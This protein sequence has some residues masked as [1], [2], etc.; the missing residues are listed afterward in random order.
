MVGS[1]LSRALDFART[2]VRQFQPSMFTSPIS[3]RSTA[4]SPAGLKHV[5]TLSPW[6]LEATPM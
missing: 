2:L 5:Q 4:M 3:F 6:A 1:I